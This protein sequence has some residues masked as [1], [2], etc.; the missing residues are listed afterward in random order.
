MVP[1]VTSRNQVFLR[2]HYVNE[3]S[4]GTRL[5]TQKHNNDIGFLP[6]NNREAR[7]EALGTRLTYGSLFESN[8]FVSFDKQFRNVG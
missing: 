3:M 4:L 8:T 2:H 6:F 1:G 5:L 7:G